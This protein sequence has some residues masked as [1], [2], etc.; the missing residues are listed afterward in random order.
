MTGNFTTGFITGFFNFLNRDSPRVWQSTKLFKWPFEVKWHSATIVKS[1]KYGEQDECIKMLKSN[2]NRRR[3]N[4]VSKKSQQKFYHN[5]ATGSGK[6]VSQPFKTH[7]QVPADYFARWNKYKAHM[8]WNM[9]MHLNA[10][11]VPLNHKGNF[12]E[13]RFY[14]HF[15]KRT[16]HRIAS[17]LVN[18]V[19]NFLFFERSSTEFHKIVNQED[20]FLISREVYGDRQMVDLWILIK[21]V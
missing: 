1:F 10:Q 8:K 21:K 13:R 7:Y 14:F 2:H 12:I 19:E 17:H 4:I 11:R 18:S 9:F 3:R 20:L 15:D 5:F 6:P 16:S